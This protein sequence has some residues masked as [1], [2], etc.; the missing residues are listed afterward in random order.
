MVASRA[1]ASTAAV[2][3]SQKLGTAGTVDV[4]NVAVNNEPGEF[5][6]TEGRPAAA[7]ALENTRL[8]G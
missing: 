7:L 8:R 1:A 4:R 3:N 5:P 6:E 2:A